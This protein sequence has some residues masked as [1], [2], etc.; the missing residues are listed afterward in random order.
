M[1]G[2]L[3]HAN[4]R[5][6]QLAGLNQPIPPGW[7]FH[8]MLSPAGGIFYEMHFLPA[9]ILRGQ[10]NEVALDLTLPAGEEV[11]V[12]VN[13]NLQKN[14]DGTPIAIRIAL[15]EAHERRR[16]ERDLLEAGR[17][18]E[19]LAEVVRR[20]SDAII[21]ASPEGIIQGWNNGAGQIFAYTHQEAVGQ[22]LSSS[23]PQHRIR[24]QWTSRSP[25]HRCR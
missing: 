14:T 25:H 19:R 2:R 13:A 16:Y 21:T 12:L 9:L 6:F 22:S 11:P 24:P 17:N 4:P 18:S 15:F 1:D 7:R 5:F 20:S 8:Q 3:L 23:R 10:L